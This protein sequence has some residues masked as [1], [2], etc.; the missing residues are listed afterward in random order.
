MRGW[1]FG[2]FRNS[3]QLAISLPEVIGRGLMFLDLLRGSLP[4]LSHSGKDALISL[5]ALP[6]TARVPT[7]ELHRDVYRSVCRAVT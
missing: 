2:T 7:H 1:C 3:S 5:L 6:S 4:R